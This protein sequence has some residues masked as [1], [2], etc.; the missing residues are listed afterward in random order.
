MVQFLDL[1]GIELH[2]PLPEAPLP[3]GFVGNPLD[4]R[5][6]YSVNLVRQATRQC[7]DVSYAAESFLLRV[8]DK[9]WAAH[10]VDRLASRLAAPTVVLDATTLDLPEL[11]LLMRG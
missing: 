10:Q 2:A 7:L 4:E 11:L 5:G 6:R 9:D 3:M 1:G 8:G